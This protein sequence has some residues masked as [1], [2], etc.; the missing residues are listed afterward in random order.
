MWQRWASLD[1]SMQADGEQYVP[2]YQSGPMRYFFEDIPAEL[3]VDDFVATW[4]S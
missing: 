3:N 4:K 2:G 1:E